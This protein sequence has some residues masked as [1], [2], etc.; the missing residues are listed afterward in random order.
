MGTADA[1]LVKNDGNVAQDFSLEANA[2]WILG[3]S[4]A[5]NQCV[6]MGLFNADTAPEAGNYNVTY[7]LIDGTTRWATT[8]AGNGLYEGLSSGENVAVDTGE[9]L[10]IY[11]K[12]PSS[13]TSGL[14]ETIT[15]TVGTREHGAE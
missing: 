3:S 8:S 10:Y 7:D 5:E 2:N 11:L 15:V 14:E 13:V 6:L 1:V 4:T 9:K 12:T